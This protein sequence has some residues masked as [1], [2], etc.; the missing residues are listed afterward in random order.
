MHRNLSI[1]SLA[2]NLKKRSTASFSSSVRIRRIFSMAIT[3]V[4]TILFSSC[5]SRNENRNFDDDNMPLIDGKRT[6]IIGSYH[7]PKTETPFKTLSQN[8]FNYVRVNADSAQISEAARNNLNVWI[9]TNAIDEKNSESSKK[10]LKEVITKFKNHSNLLF[11][12]IED[13]PA[14]TWMSKEARVS[15]EK[16]KTAYDFI[17]SIDNSHAIF[18]NHAPVNLISTLKRYNNS[19]ELVAVDVYPVVPHG[20]KPT[21]A[22]H[23]D[24]LQG[25]LLNTYSSQVGEYIDKMKIVVEDKKPV[26][27][28]LQG[29]AWEMLK[30]E[31]ERDTSMI[32]YPTYEQSR[33][34]AYNAIVHG[35]KGVIYWGT[36]YTPQPSQFIT[37]L[38]RVTGELAGMQEVLSAKDAE[39][40]ISIEYHELGHSVDTGVEFITKNINGKMYLITTNS[41]KNPVKVTFSGL[42]NLKEVTVLKENRKFKIE[43]GK[44]TDEYEPFDVH[45]Y[46]I[47]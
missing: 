40:S 24:G 5:T 13:E 37:D 47:E 11:W 45:L 2:V 7:H 27:A 14:Y 32:L 21:Y 16:L 1:K 20:I 22:L 34:M 12:E 46:K 33:F 39:N 23:R 17:K 26:F 36:N 8:G 41:D 25:D 29:F 15:P 3:F 4:I 44:F 30:P 42:N 19:C 9:Y 38:Y 28:V 6:F 31:N 10:S 35:A 18:T 43:D